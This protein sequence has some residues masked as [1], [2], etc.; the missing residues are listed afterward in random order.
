MVERFLTLARAQSGQLEEHNQVALEPLIRS[1]LNDRADQIAAKELT[2]E[3]DLDVVGVAGSATLLR[4]MIENVIENAV[5]HTTPCGLV[6]IA[7]T[8]AGSSPAVTI[9]R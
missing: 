7:L 6:E 2:I 4:R 1:A 3:T 9:R 8:S 5:R